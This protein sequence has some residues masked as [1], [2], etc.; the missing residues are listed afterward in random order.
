MPLVKPAA[1]SPPQFL[2][3]EVV[4]VPELGEDAEVLV[5]ELSL[6]GRLEF[7]DALRTPRAST[8]DLVPRLLALSV[9]GE[10]DVPL[11]SVEQWQAW[12]ARHRDRSVQLFNVAMRV[13]GLNAAD[14]E[15]N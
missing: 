10:A 3:R 14:A 12:G 5:V 15:K 2:A 6:A 7:E 8:H 4:P 1:V 9:L 13:S 11:F